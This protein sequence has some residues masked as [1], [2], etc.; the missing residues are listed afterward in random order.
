MKL[1][2]G[3][4]EK[5]IIAALKS[6][7]QNF[8]DSI[9]IKG[10][11]ADYGVSSSK[12]TVLVEKLKEFTGKEVDI[13]SFWRFT[14]I[15]EFI[16]HI[17]DDESNIQETV[18][19]ESEKQDDI[20]CVNDKDEYAIIGMAC[21]FPNADN[22]N[23]YW[24]N[25]S[26]G[27]DCITTRKFGDKEIPGGY[28]KNIDLFDSRFF[29]ILPVEAEK[30]DPQQRHLLEVVWE[31]FE[32]ANIKPETLFGTDAGVFVGISSNDYAN[33]INDSSNSYDI[34]NVIGNSHA[35]ASN[36]I[37]YF[38]NF[39]GPSVSVDTACSSS[40][41]ALHYAC[42]SLKNDDCD[43]AV[44]AGA[45]AI[46][47]DDI[48]N[49]FLNSRMLSPD[50]K[51]KTF[52]EAA[53]GYVRGE[54]I[55][56]VI[57]KK[58]SCALKDGNHIY[59]SVLG[60]AVNQDGKSN[61]LTSPNL[62]SQVKLIKKAM[63]NASVTANDIQ[64]L[65]AHG[66]GTN[67]GD[68]IEATAIG[69]AICA[70][71]NEPLRIGSVKT[72]I[73][74]LEAAA[75]I[76]GLIKTVL[77]L[78]HKQF[79]PSIN[80]Q[81]L[82][83][84]ILFEREKLSVQTQTEEWRSD[85]RRIAGISSFGFG[86]T[87]S[88]AIIAENDNEPNNAVSDISEFTSFILPVS[89]KTE[90]SLIGNCRNAENFL[91][92]NEERALQIAAAYA[93]NRTHFDKRTA[94]VIKDKHFYQC[95]KT[96]GNTSRKK[97][98][99]VFS[100]QGPGKLNF[101]G[102]LMKNIFFYS[103][104]KEIDQAFMQI[105][106]WSVCDV[107]NSVSD[108][109]F[110][111][112]DV[113]QPV[114]FAV[115]VSLVY[116]LEQYGIKPDGVVGHSLGEIAAAY[117]SGKLSLNDALTVIYKR[118]CI[119]QR[120][121]GKGRMLS[122]D[123]TELET[124]KLLED[125]G[126][127]DEV[128][129]A[130]VNSKDSCVVSGNEEK[131]EKLQEY[132]NDNGIRNKMLG[133]NYPFH[134]KEAEQ[135][136]NE[137]LEE[138][139][140]IKL[141]SNKITAYSTVTGRKSDIRAFGAKYWSTQ[142]Y[143]PVLFQST[144]NSMVDDSYD[145]FIE[146]NTHAIVSQ[147]L[148]KDF[149]NIKIMSVLNKG[150]EQD[151]SVS[152]LIGKL[153]MIGYDID[154]E[155]YYRD[156]SVK[157]E[158]IPLYSWEN[159]HCWYEADEIKEKRKCISLDTINDNADEESA[160]VS[161]ISWFKQL[162]AE[163]TKI[164][165]LNI[166]DDDRMVELGIYSLVAY[167]ICDK[168]NTKYRCNISREQLI[169]SD[170][171]IKEIEDF[172]LNNSH[173][174]SINNEIEN[175]V[176]DVSDMQKLFWSI[177][178]ADSTN[179]AY[180]QILSADVS[181]NVDI[182][183]LKNAIGQLILDHDEL[184]SR[185]YIENG[186]VVK[187]FMNID[188]MQYFIFNKDEIYSDEE[189]TVKIAEFE[190]TPFILEKGNL[191]KVYFLRKKDGYVLVVCAHHSVIDLASI[192]ILISQMIE[193]YQR[194][195][196][197]HPIKMFGEKKYDLF[198]AEHKNY[199]DSEAGKSDKDFWTEKMKGSLPIIDLAVNNRPSVLTYDGD[200]YRNQISAD[201]N[202]EII[203]LA[204]QLNVT[205]YVLLMS[206]YYVLIYKYT[207]EKDII[208]GMSSTLRNEFNCRDTVGDFVN[209]LPVRLQ[210]TSQMTFEDFVNV[211]KN[212]ISESIKHQ[213]YS[214]KRI[215]E[216]VVSVVQKGFSPIVQVAFSQEELSVN[217]HGNVSSF[218]TGHSSN[219]E[220][221]DVKLSVRESDI[222][223]TPYDLLL[224]A[225]TSGNTLNLSWQYNINV[226]DEEFIQRMSVHFQT[227]IETIIKSPA[228][229]ISDIRILTDDELDLLLNK[230]NDD[231]KDYDSRLF[232]DAFED[233]VKKYSNNIA[234]S[235]NGKSETY[236][237]FNCKINQT[238]RYLQSLGLKKGDYVSVCLY[239]S[240]ETL[241]L[242]MAILKIGCVY[243]PIDPEYHVSRIGYI[244]EET[245][246]KVAF[247][248][249]E[250]SESINEQYDTKIQH[251]CDILKE[252]DNFN[253]ADL[254]VEIKANDLAYIIFTSGTTGKPKGVMI[255]HIGICNMVRGLN[256]GWGVTDT[257]K[258]LQFASLSFDASIAE[259]F[260]TFLSGAE[261]VLKLKEDTL[262][263]GALERTLKSE[264]I[265]DVIL[266]PSVLALADET[267]LTDLRSVLSAGESCNSA[268]IKKWSSGRRFINAYGPTETTV[269][270]S[271]KICDYADAENV[272]IGKAIEGTK[273][274]ILD[275]DMN[276]VPL[277]MAG[278]LCITSVGNARGYFNE[279]KLTN[280]KFVD[281]KLDKNGFQKIYRTNDIVRYSKD[282]NIKFCGRKDN[283]VKIRG[284]RIEIDEIEN[285]ISK[286]EGVKECVVIVK[287]ISQD[288][289]LVA[290]ICSSDPNCN[291]ATLRSQIRKELAPYMIPS[292]FEFVDELPHSINGKV[293]R[294]LVSTFDIKNQIVQ[295]DDS[296]YT[297]TQKKLRKIWCNAFGFDAITIEDDFYELGGHSLLA[298][299]IKTQ[300][301][302]E[303]N[304]S[305]E[306]A[307]IL[308]HSSFISLC[309][310]I[311]SSSDIRRK[312]NRP[313]EKL[314]EANYIPVTY[315][316]KRLLF[317]DCLNN[318]S[319]EYN[320][321]G[322]LLLT[323]ELNV[324]IFK[325][326]YLNVIKNNTSLRTVFFK[327]NNIYYQRINDDIECFELEYIKLEDQNEINRKVEEIKNYNFDLYN[328]P[329]IKSCLIETEYQKYIL[330]F[331][332]HHIIS[333]GTSVALMVD[334]WSREYNSLL[335]NEKNML[336]ESFQFSDYAIWCSE[337]I[338]GRKLEKLDEYWLRRLKGS[339]NELLDLVTDYPRKGVMTNS[340]EYY[341][342]NIDEELSSKLHD[343]CT[344]KH[345][346]MFMLLFVS[347]N[348]LLNKLTGKEHFNIGV[349]MA[350]RNIQN[351]QEILG[352]FINTVVMRTMIDDN[353]SFDELLNDVKKNSISDFENQEM[354]FDR[355]VEILNPNRNLSY[356]PLFQIL[357]N[358][359]NIQEPVFDLENVK[360]SI[361]EQA[362]HNSKYDL[363]VYASDGK[364]V[365][366]DFLYNNDLYSRAHI[367]IMSE[368]Y[369]EVLR[370]IA[371]NSSVHI[372]DICIN[373]TECI[374]T[375]QEIEH[376]TEYLSL[377]LKTA[378]EKYSENIAVINKD[379]I[380]FSYGELKEKATEYAHFFAKHIIDEYVLLYSSRNYEMICAVIGCI[381]SGKNF[382]IIDSNYPIRRIE[383]MIDSI[384]ERRILDISQNNDLMQKIDSRYHDLILKY[385]TSDNDNEL[386][387]YDNESYYL[388]F[389][390]GTTGIPKA[391]KS[392]LSCVSHFIDWYKNEFAIVE[393]DRF[394]MLSG[395]SHDPIMRDIFSP[396]C[397]GASVC[398]PNDEVLI[399]PNAINN[400]LNKNRITII[401][402]T[403]SVLKLFSENEIESL[404]LIC[405][406]GERMDSVALKKAKKIAPRSKIINFYGTSETPQVMSYFDAT[407]CKADI[408]P[409]GKGISGVNVLV[410][411]KNMN[412]AGI[413]GVGEIIIK[414][415][416]LSDGYI[417]KDT[418]NDAFI[419][420]SGCS[421][422]KTGDIGFYDINGNVVMLS[423]NDKQVKN[424]GFRIEVSEIEK[425]LLAND[426]IKDSKVKIC[427]NKLTA[428]VVS[429]NGKLDRSKV[430]KELMDKLP[431]YMIPDKF[432]VL[433][434]MPLTPNGK[435]D[436]NSL[437]ELAKSKTSSNI[438]I[439]GNSDTLEIVK[440][441]YKEILQLDDLDIDENF[442][443]LG[444]Y[445][446]QL[447]DLN[448]KI[449]SLLDEK[450]ELID[451]YKYPTVRMFSDYIDSKKKGVETNLIKMVDVDTKKK[452]LRNRSQMKKR[453]NI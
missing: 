101:S 404:R 144:I 45:N 222:R 116:M 256:K 318:D 104:I 375:D 233:I 341:S 253:M 141:R 264:Q 371:S 191:F 162:I 10:N 339:E 400:W 64:Y 96:E 171:T 307:A 92:Q 276:P 168:I 388:V 376:D 216:N 68:P 210:L 91:K 381:I 72:M 58:K 174:S 412:I 131:I 87:N 145:L 97:V 446:L 324:D 36:R 153:Y 77:C 279:P 18:F 114:I 337:N 406:G 325:K 352:M 421:A 330:V 75:G 19:N 41:V 20:S 379:G 263:G 258:V 215:L 409:I 205:P 62:S 208:I 61:G 82:N 343:I 27:A 164:E 442:F 360:T 89:A 83:S 69:E 158:K 102:E 353:M 440:N 126:F 214:Y 363:T 152:D 137:L 178:S 241:E 49:V 237:E 323:G 290:F 147:Y 167:D 235:M 311:D 219:F 4:I 236:Y 260:I 132:F 373:K 422:Y 387:W 449:S 347:F 383:K 21:R 315:A 106:G 329:L 398:I 310:F 12:L 209:L 254:D 452:A 411:D 229:K 350:G 358:M 250:I 225:D 154:W 160:D 123:L 294:K 344:E 13:N 74:H 232:I 15:E 115:Q 438:D 26:S 71:R 414:T 304:I 425:E 181:G 240:V 266:T 274:Y 408:I 84:K 242:L 391:I 303:F 380:Q 98:A 407:E 99:F 386:L 429:D 286:C 332:V 25:L 112:T 312:N 52:D 32:D 180:N 249:P 31:A 133:V 81:K 272:T 127:N 213:K 243:I 322:D 419:E 374:S 370:Q 86:G 450:F 377:A 53:N 228:S 439:S 55:G 342:F 183:K 227:I 179:C 190:N 293:D 426:E 267:G 149:D 14:S 157:S 85:K 103:R 163:Y 119:M 140:S 63:K 30:I 109:N 444:G 395:L 212:N 451:L 220:F 107:L 401:H 40:L 184:R 16:D 136:E 431:M 316:Q 65:E 364:N 172:I 345:V 333:D 338:Q 176:I 300:I 130:V 35:V 203:S 335:K 327:E 230:F 366:F 321:S 359:M 302:K 427:D 351:T 436:E 365:K 46:L 155:N 246:A 122:I 434:S 117:V 135:Y 435:I 313:I 226:L 326:S 410:V 423:R 194:L 66:T 224:M 424:R 146:F 39:T 234:V 270:A 299:E 95:K 50:F 259:I 198:I 433:K 288:K 396:I 284:F 361:R 42:M 372:S 201:I 202:S 223:Y 328:P 1:N 206:V 238:A 356:S 265:T 306:V 417:S 255:E 393:N 367:K 369:I 24:N 43:I 432:I 2:K 128:R 378:F 289:R 70:H 453:R 221:A 301:E 90:K 79:V 389:T 308:N 448:E 33:N 93:K 331:A 5:E 38:Y 56:A 3:E 193:N 67:L 151:T 197:G 280:E 134:G 281:N 124:R 23:E 291:E 231:V 382:A 173:E 385:E 355:L 413:M 275:D 443:D 394:S 186:I 218:I 282:G 182:A 362:S 121:K 348:I 185:F 287:E 139:K 314:N 159:T 204:K 6:V 346:T 110:E 73:G 416:Y 298:N 28:I 192:E 11:F 100:G 217:G 125:K 247:I 37:S 320:I 428:F 262:P 51:C 188:E 108:K 405:L 59:A 296:S 88:H 447:I 44:V 111:D 278:E 430:K 60:S 148:K 199:L 211:V 165:P 261:L 57:L 390:S 22:L 142:I 418:A 252:R 285:V 105:S 189:I 297:E 166:S 34:N 349:P 277:G 336:T 200:V 384:S 415:K 354:P 269:C 170:L 319:T 94:Y 271:Y 118:S 244:L 207:S 420:I 177:Y 368:Q 292:I 402:Q 257:S 78:E 317:V 169:D 196:A 437:D 273:L 239:K 54:G 399:V 138:L 76:A 357:F 309:E 187:E 7:D 245:S 9:D 248:E 143:K 340:G 29:K 445:S 397:C 47:N 161:E 48:T 175:Y 403:S 295:I 17:V 251:I 268:I 305:I 195:I 392:R 156:I 80:F 334:M 441:S 113:A 120:L 8:P 150:I 283:Q 129:V